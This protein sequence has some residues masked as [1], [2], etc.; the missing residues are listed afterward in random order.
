MA[1]AAGA[2]SKPAVV[3]KLVTNSLP[4]QGQKFS[5]DFAV[6]ALVVICFIAMRLWRLT[7]AS[8]DGDEMCSLLL[9]RYSWHGFLGAAVKEATHPPLFYL[10]LKLWISIGGESLFWLRLL[11]MTI[12]ALCLVPFF[13]LSRILELRPLA[14]NL[15][16]VIAAVHPY[17]IFYAQHLRM[18]GL[19]MLLALL[20]V[21]CFEAYLKQPSFRRLAFLCVVNLAMVYT[22]YYAW[23]IVGIELLFLI[24]QRRRWQP[25][26]VAIMLTAIAF[27]PWLWMASKML[28]S[29]GMNEKVGWIS[30]PTLTDLVWFF[31]DLTGC[32]DHL[33]SYF[34]KAVAILSILLI[35]FFACRRGR[36]DITH[37]L[38]IFAI[39]PA[40]L[41][42]GVSQWLPLWGHRH[43]IFMFWPFVIVLADAVFRL[44]QRAIFGVLMLTAV[45]TPFALEVHY[46]DDRKLPWDT[47][48]LTLL[49]KEQ[50]ASSP[51]PFYS[52]DRD[53][54]FPPWFFMDCLKTGNLGPFGP[55]LG[56][57][58]DIAELAT[59]AA[60]F[61]I[62]KVSSPDAVRGKHF[63]LGYSDQNE[64]GVQI[65]QQIVN[66]PGCRTGDAIGA[67]DR[68]HSV[69][70][71]PVQCD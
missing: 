13:W 14:R 33:N 20:S 5:V 26:A 35:V 10:L 3:N 45:W 56:A 42:F 31:A 9:A 62:A 11:P 28:R 71:V 65:A 8:L 66:R 32:A 49:T 40:L 6:S 30:R 70:F 36:N 25:F 19:L 52:L 46:H 18:Y 34:A 47:L 16:L 39:A 44:P 43:L 7:A 54:H 51:V 61:Q 68:F 41:L 57:R 64:Q 53:L 22:H 23:M 15:A 60:K 37:R 21:C 48:T 1:T 63:W 67:R 2:Q 38:A 50:G 17:A 59:T 69:T 27:T 24:W 29:G 58:K 12:S 55:H 4:G